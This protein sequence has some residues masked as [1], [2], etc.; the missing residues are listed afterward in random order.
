VADPREHGQRARGILPLVLTEPPLAR[1]QPQRVRHAGPQPLVGRP[2]LRPAQRPRRRQLDRGGGQRARSEPHARV[3][4]VVHPQVARAVESPPRARPLQLHVDPLSRPGGPGGVPG[5]VVRG[6]SEQ[7]GRRDH[8]R[9]VRGSELRQGSP[10]LPDRR[11]G[12]LTRRSSASRQARCGGRLLSC[13]RPSRPGRY[14]SAEFGH[15]PPR[16]LA[17]NLQNA[18]WPLSRACRAEQDA[19]SAGAEYRTISKAGPNRWL[20]FVQAACPGIAR[21]EAAV[22]AA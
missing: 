17:R 19:S 1:Q 13:T 10:Q 6:A 5:R 11:R 20:R 2:A 12:H 4:V 16:A 3:A 21:V 7:I 8:V 14:P 18:A 9:L 22:A 15:V